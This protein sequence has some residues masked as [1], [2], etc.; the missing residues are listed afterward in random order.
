MLRIALL[1]LLQL[2]VT[3][4]TLGWVGRWLGLRMKHPGF[5]PMASLAL[6]FAPPVL[7][8]SLACYLADKFN[9]TRLPERQ[10][11]PMMMWLALAIGC[12]HCLVLSVWAATRLRHQLR[13]VAMSRYQPLPPWRWRL[14]S[15]RAV[16]RFAIGA[17]A[18][19]AVVA[20]LVVSYYGYQNWR[21][22]RAW[23]T[24]QAALKQSGESLNLS[25]LLP[26]PAPDDANFA[27]S[28]AFLGLLSKT[29]RETT[30]LFERMRSFEPPASGVPGNAFLMDWSRQT[31]SPLHPFVNWTRQQSRGGSGTNRAGGRSGHL[32]GPAIPERDVARTGGRSGPSPRFSNLDQPRCQR[33]SSSRP[34]TNA[35][36]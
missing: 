9:L 13:P 26:E 12:G 5:A 28:P 14:P 30:A 7:L 23:R 19:A 16:R 4:P 15:W 21:S 34:G 6:L 31:N 22:K 24:F 18:F 33:S 1:I 36:A 20:L 32:A 17:A 25:P 35:P 11:L 3:W 2:M 27:R 8:F 10:F 29:N